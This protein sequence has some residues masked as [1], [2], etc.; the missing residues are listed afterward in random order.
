MKTPK[1]FDYDLWTSNEG[2]YFIRIKS[3]G[4]TCEVNRDIMRLLRNEEKKLRRELQGI[5]ITVS[6]GKEKPKET[7]SIALLSLDC[8]ITDDT[9]QSAWLED[10]TNY[11]EIVITKIRQEDFCK[12]LT[13]LQVE[14]FKKCLLGGLPYLQLAKQIGV[15]E[16]TI[17]WSVK[18]I[19]KKAKT[20]FK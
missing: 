19:Q 4:E 6:K 8:V 17:R 2:G 14:I 20:F 7:I 15:Q 10:T 16:G 13:E 5:T 11:E 3:T 9:V 1:D 18:K 12:I